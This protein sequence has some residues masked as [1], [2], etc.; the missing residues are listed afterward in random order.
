M[1]RIPGMR[2]PRGPEAVIQP[3]SP[4]EVEASQQKDATDSDVGDIMAEII[5]Q[6]E[7][8]YPPEAFNQ[9]IDEFTQ[10]IHTVPELQS[11]DSGTVQK[12]IEEH[13]GNKDNLNL[14]KRN[15]SSLSRSENLKKFLSTSKDKAVVIAAE[16][17]FLKA[18]L[19]GHA[20]NFFGDGI[21]SI[22]GAKLVEWSLRNSRLLQDFYKERGT[23]EKD[24]EVPNDSLGEQYF[25]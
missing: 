9:N 8:G 19:A 1:R 21:S 17:G 4:T 15:I 3:T 25:Q 13:G 10:E 6:V 23:I 11:V 12:L 20:L 14:F 7:K 16:T 18:Y 2:G 22:I 5:E 24:V